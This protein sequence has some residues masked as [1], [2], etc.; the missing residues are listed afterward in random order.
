[1]LAFFDRRFIAIEGEKPR[2]I[3]RRLELDQPLRDAARG[4]VVADHRD[5][6]QPLGDPEARAAV[7]KAADAPAA[8]EADRLE[9][10]ARRVH[11]IEAVGGKLDRLDRRHAW[12]EED[13]PSG[14]VALSPLVFGTALR[15]AAPAVRRARNVPAPAEDADRALARVVDRNRF[16]RHAVAF[17]AVGRIRGPVL[18]L[19]RAIA[20]QRVRHDRFPVVG[21]KD[22][23]KAIEPRDP[24]AA[25]LAKKRDNSIG[26]FGKR[27]IAA[28]YREVRHVLR[29]QRMAQLGQ[30]ARDLRFDVVERFA[31]RDAGIVQGLRRRLARRARGEHL[32]ARADAS[33]DGEARRAFTDQRRDRRVLGAVAL[34]CVHR[35]LREFTRE[36]LA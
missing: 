18:E 8:Q 7:E 28:A 17:A 35:P 31:R 6:V 4:A 9:R 1:M 20:H 12:N 19:V 2:Q 23:R 10:L 22:D 25:I 32:D 15:L 30:R 5:L 21:R 16:E 14:K 3:D 13:E 33:A 11:R 26:H 27:E 36:L 29:H 24:I 34:Q